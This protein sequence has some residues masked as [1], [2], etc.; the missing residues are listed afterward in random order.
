[1]LQARLL[2]G[3]L[4]LSAPLLCGEQ[5]T[6]A[7]PRIEKRK[8]LWFS[9]LETPAQVEAALGKPAMAASSGS[10]HLSWQFRLGG[11]DHHDFSHVLVFRKS[12]SKLVSVTRLYEEEQTVDEFFP[13]RETTVHQYPGDGTPD[14]AKAAF[15]LRLRR[16]SGGRLLIAMGSPKPGVPT[17][18]LVLMDENELTTAYPWLAE[19]L[20]Q[21][22]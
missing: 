13:P 8:L 17:G 15:S 16:L 14:A 6:A 20:R 21:R 10:D 12:T 1:M 4:I 3:A 9:L 22:R 7:D 5:P 2:F 18:Q 11:I 19:Q